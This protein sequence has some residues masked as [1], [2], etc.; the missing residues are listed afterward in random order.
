MKL[1]IDK[2]TINLMPPVHF[3]G[4]IHLINNAADARQAVNYLSRQSIIGFDTETRPSFKKGDTHNVALIQLST[5]DECFLFRVNLFGFSEPLITLLSDPNVLKIGLSTKDDFNGLN[6]LSPFTPGGFV[7]LQN[8]VKEYGIYEMSLQKIYAIIFG[9]HMSKGQRLSNWEAQELSTYQ[10]D[11]AALD[12]WACLHI[13]DYLK[14]GNFDPEHSY[15]VS[16]TIS[17][18]NNADT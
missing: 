1:T 12:A 18:D 14:D 17:N 3:Q 4:S 13:Y 6:R 2:N 5:H 10:Q 15:G 7:E 16:Q 9:Q 8:F 11:Y